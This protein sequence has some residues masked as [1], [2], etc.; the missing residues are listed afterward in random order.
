MTV[1]LGLLNEYSPAPLGM[2][3]LLVQAME[4]MPGM[5]METRAEWSEAEQV[6]VASGNHFTMMEEHAQSVADAVGAWL[7]ELPE[8]KAAR[9]VEV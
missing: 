5:G 2:P 1:Y 7:S 6:L 8:S 3:G 9:Q 4:A